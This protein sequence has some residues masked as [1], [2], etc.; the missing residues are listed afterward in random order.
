MR[1]TGRPT[2][3]CSLDRPLPATL[4]SPHLMNVFSLEQ[5]SMIMVASSISC[6]AGMPCTQ[7][8][9][10]M[11]GG[12]RGVRRQGHSR[13]HVRCSASR[14]RTAAGRACESV[15]SKHTPTQH[16]GQ[17]GAGEGST[18]TAAGRSGKSQPQQQRT[19]HLGQLVAGRTASRLTTLI[20]LYMHTQTGG[21][22]TILSSLW[23]ASSKSRADMMVR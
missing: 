1:P 3:L 14:H 18:H 19:H 12:G 16:G 15:A 17:A 7:A 20:A 11:E 21:A 10:R 22:P 2:A 6:P 4:P 8:R 9:D 23:P 5:H 13:P